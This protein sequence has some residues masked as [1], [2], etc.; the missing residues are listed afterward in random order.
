[1]STS[2][3]LRP[4]RLRIFLVE[5]H[6]DTRKYLMLYLEQMGHTIASAQS[7]EEALATIPCGTWDLLI[8]DIG[9]PDGNGWELMERLGSSRPPNAI[10]M[11]G[12]GMTNDMEK[13]RAVGYR[14]H[15]IKPIDLDEFDRVLAEVANENEE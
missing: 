10:A 11:S 4:K 2:S 6:F 5:N 14:D 13:S 7:M 3:H 8:S 9:L 15:L 1:M 12:F